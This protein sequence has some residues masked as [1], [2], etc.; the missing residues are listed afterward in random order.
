MKRQP[1]PQL[2]DF[3]SAYD[4]HVADLA[5]ALRAMLFEEAPD[6]VEIVYRNH[7][8]AVWYGFGPRMSH[9]LFYIAAARSHVNLGFCRGASLSDSN[10]VLEGEG[11]V[12]RHIK[13]RSARDLER[14]FVRRYVRSAMEQVRK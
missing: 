12:M 1:D 2:F 7:P 13:F 10:R 9:M 3:L 6:A 8:A 4:R 5:L 14:P 11:N